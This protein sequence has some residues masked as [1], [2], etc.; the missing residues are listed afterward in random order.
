MSPGT[1]VLCR[2]TRR[3]LNCDTFR[4]I[5]FRC[6][7]WHHVLNFLH[8]WYTARRLESVKNALRRRTGDRVVYYS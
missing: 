5:C 3:N 2:T 1:S 7:F 8:Q 4:S 6:A